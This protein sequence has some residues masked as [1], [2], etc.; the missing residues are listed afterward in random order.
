MP[1][2]E[3]QKALL[4]ECQKY[5]IDIN[6]VRYWWHKSKRISAFIVAE[7]RPTYEQVRN[8]IIAEMKKYAPKYPTVTREKV[9]DK[10]LLVV[11]P[12]DVH[13][14]KLSLNDETGYHYDIK[15]AVRYAEEGVRG[16]VAKASGFPI[17][18]ILLIVG[19][20]VLH[21]DNPFRTTTAGTKQDTDS[22]WWDAFTTARKMY[23]RIIEELRANAPVDVVFNPSNH[24]Y[25]SGY[26][27]VDALSCWFH[28]A[29][30]VRFDVR[31]RHRKY[32]RY[33]VSMLAFTHGDGAKSA[34]MPLLM[35]QEEKDMWAKTTHRY[36]YQHHLHHRVKTSW[37]SV[38]DYPGVTLTVLRS[39]SAPDGWAH[40]N[41]YVGAP[42][43]I[44]GFVHSR[45]YG[46]VARLTHFVK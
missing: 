17:E 28:T 27:L 15:T 30:D 6:S 10:H 5:G 8:G 11:D 4:E 25:A 14:G 33:G 44:E 1:T 12:A 36:I 2:K 45:K 18:R 24:D 16:V 29:S 37:Q 13:I 22:M 31:I 7:K 20:D 41:G 21:T 3:Q 39:P 40:R 19:N 46:Q 34:D 26:M 43:A 35:A 42:L 38:K 23:V 9:T 32:Y